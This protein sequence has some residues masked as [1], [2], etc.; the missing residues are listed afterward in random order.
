MKVNH[1]VSECSLQCTAKQHTMTAFQTMLFFTGR[2]S[3]LA[4]TQINLF[5]LSDKCHNKDFYFAM[6]ICFF[7]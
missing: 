7:Y 6:F 2:M 3:R 1:C 5:F 4:K